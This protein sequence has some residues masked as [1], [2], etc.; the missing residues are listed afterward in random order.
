MPDPLHS[1]STAPS[2]PTALAD[3]LVALKRTRSA[4]NVF[5]VIAFAAV[6]A[7]LAA[8]AMVE[9]IGYFDGDNR[10]ISEATLGPAAVWRE[11]L[12]ATLAW[13]RLASVPAATGL[14]LSLF[15]Y[16]LISL[17]GRMGGTRATAGAFFWS[18]W[19]WLLT[20]PWGG[21]PLDMEG[22]GHYSRSS[23]GV[24]FEFGRPEVRSDGREVYPPDSLM[25][26]HRTLVRLRRASAEREAGLSAEGE[27]ASR[28]ST[29]VGYFTRFL[30]YPTAVVILMLTVQVRFSRAYL[31]TVRLREAV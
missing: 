12:D 1:E 16:L 19:V 14:M 29:E 6:L 20:M 26:R 18:V 8:F 27:P 11:S 25:G 22:R 30:L 28:L 21:L 5:W 10:L 7:D 24:V 9:W 17:T 15:V 3:F 13:A 4:K 2:T 31:E 23:M